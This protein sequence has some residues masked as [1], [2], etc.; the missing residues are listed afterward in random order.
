MAKIEIQN[1]I[2]RLIDYYNTA[3]KLEID[4]PCS[5]AVK[6]TSAWLYHQNKHG[7]SEQKKYYEEQTEQYDADD[8]LFE[9]TF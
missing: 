5:Y 7:L 3:K 1:V 9:S 6:K 8:G 2:G 4:D